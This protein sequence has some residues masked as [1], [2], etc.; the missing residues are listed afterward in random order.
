[1]LYEK[2]E[3]AVQCSDIYE[4]ILNGA[5]TIKELRRCIREDGNQGSQ[6]TTRYTYLK[7]NP[8]YIRFEND[9]VSIDKE[10]MAADIEE[11]LRHVCDVDVGKLRSRIKELEDIVSEQEG[12]IQELRLQGVKADMEKKVLVPKSIKV[13]P[14]KDPSE[15][16]FL[17]DPKTL[18]DVEKIV[19]IYGGELKSFYEEISTD[20]ERPLPEGF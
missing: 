9:H 11:V 6:I 17:D 5:D 20:P 1:M 12:L 13:G 19:S 8:A 18:L 14:Q 3:M 7:N 15:D 2:L 4:F 16:I 10:E